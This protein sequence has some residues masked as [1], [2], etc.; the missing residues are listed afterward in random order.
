MKKVILVVFVMKCYSTWFK[1]GIAII[2]C[3]FITHSLTGQVTENFETG[4]LEKWVESTA[5]HWKADSINPLSGKYSLHHIFDNPEA[6]NDQTGLPVKNLKPSMGLTTWSFKLKHGYDPSSSNNWGV[7]LIS[8]NA[9]S[10]MIPGGVVNG[11]VLGV[12]LSGYD[13]TLRLW[14]IKSGILLPVLNSGINW[15]NDIGANSFATISIE[16]SQTGTWRTKV[17]SKLMVP[18]DSASGSDEELFSAEWFG[19]YYKYSSTRDRLLWVD[20]ISITGVFYED[21]EPPEVT[22][23]SAITRSSVDVRLNEEP[24]DSFYDTKNFSLNSASADAIKIIK[25]SPLYVR[26]FFADQ[27]Q[28]KVE[29]TLLIRSACDKAGN[30]NRNF[31]VRFTPVWAETGDVII[32]EAMADPSP[33]VSLPEEE[34]LEIFNR[35]INKFYLKKWSL[36]KDGNA[37]TFPESVINPGEYLILCQLQDTSFFSKFGKVCGLKSF[38]VLNDG[39]GMIVLADSTGNMIH[40]IEYSSKWYEDKL[41][42]NGGWSLEMIDTA[43]PFL[44][45]GNWTASVSK[46]GGTPGSPNSVSSSNRDLQFKGIT[47]AFPDDSMRLEV[48][49]SEPVLNLNENIGGIHINSQFID[50]IE[51]A[52]PLQRKYI[53]KPG[54]PFTPHQQYSLSVTA[55]VTD[56]AGNPPMVSSFVFGLPEDAIISDVMFN[57]ILFNSKP[58]GSEYIELYNSSSKTIDAS[59]L[60]LASVNESGKYSAAIPLSAGPRCIMPGTYF[61][62]TN[63]REFLLNNYLSAVPENIFEVGQLPSMPDDKGHLVLLNRQLELIDELI[64]NEKMHYSLLSGFEG[65]ALEK[66]RPQLPSADPKN[67]HSASET[68]GWGTPGAVNSVYSIIP[69]VDDRIVFSSK[70]ITP[71]NDG[72]DDLLTIDLNLEGTGNVVT[73]TVFDETGGYVRKLTENFLAGPEASIV[74]DGT[75]QDGSLVRS[76]IYVFLI[77]VFDDHGK[78]AKWKKVCAVVR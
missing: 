19:I 49:F 34:Y 14:K 70:K 17:Y 30:C 63:D 52:D 26:I 60:L 32:S 65:I 5:G 35:T 33:A 20:D 37:S 68:C 62:I 21:K 40:G 10:N 67:W 9:P 57:E 73:I 66:V 76:G 43:F 45:E 24:D 55:K 31:N 29:N 27:I 42:E 77:S 71:D 11:F 22:S 61:T 75:A 72:N 78:V 8:D 28:N 58:G 13:D 4:Q 53:I 25:F 69:T 16:R 47:N 15:Q 39:G 74:W 64:Y 23:C 1:T 44:F 54:F 12:N 59:G 48:T 46:K 6:G 51:L 38:P 36:V 50:S 56:F 2:I 7:F 18:I 3:S 41:K